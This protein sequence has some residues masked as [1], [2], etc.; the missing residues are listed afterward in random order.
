MQKFFSESD[1]AQMEVLVI[2]QAADPNPHTTR[3]CGGRFLRLD[4]K[5]EDIIVDLVVLSKRY[6]KE[7]I[8]VPGRTINGK[9][10]QF[11]DRE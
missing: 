9:C 11:E 3:K 8:W 5:R 1:P 7:L 6:R 4:V 2:G 10:E